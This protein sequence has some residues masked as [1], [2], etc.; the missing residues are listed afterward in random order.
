MLVCKLA[1]YTEGKERPQKR[2]TTLDWLVGFN[3][4]GHLFTSIVLEIHKMSKPPPLPARIV[5]VYIEVLTECS[6]VYH[7]YGLNNT[8]LF[9]DWVSENGSTCGNHGQSSHS[10]GMGGH[11]E[12]PIFPGLVHR[13]SSSHI[14][15]I[16]S[17]NNFI[18]SIFDNCHNIILYSKLFFSIQHHT[19]HFELPCHSS[20][21]SSERVPQHFFVLFFFMT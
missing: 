3:K 13:L 4:Q 21:S 11:E 14:L 7:P 17:S 15:S 18:Y 12:P 8:V 20:Y 16:T 9:K 10:Q 19:L 6:H 5:K 2:Q 1:S